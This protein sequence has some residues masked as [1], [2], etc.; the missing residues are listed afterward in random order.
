MFTGYAVQPLITLTVELFIKYQYLQTLQYLHMMTN[1]TANNTP[2]KKKLRGLGRG[3]D[4]LL[5]I[6]H[7]NVTAQT[8]QASTVLT[9]QLQSGAYQPRTHM[10]EA[11][12]NTLAE[13]IKSQGLIQPILVRALNT[14]NQGH[15]Q[16]EIIAGERRWRAS[17]IAGLTEVPVLI[18]DISNENAAVIALIENIQREN[19]NPLEEAQGINRLIDE[20]GLTHD[21]AAHAVGRSRSAVSNLLRLLNLCQPVQTMLIAGDLDMGH[22]RAL[23]PL[24]AANQIQVAHHIVQKQLSVRD[25]EKLVNTTLLKLEPA[26]TQTNKP[27]TALKTPQNPDTNRLIE[28]LSDSLGAPVSVD[29]GKNGK[30]KLT[31]SFKGLDA[32]QGII[33]KIESHNA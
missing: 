30:G 1:S 26:S 22:A 9:S 29:I 10:D 5:G 2:A 17:Q 14:S 13:S 12:L 27:S 33:E 18:K 11:A 24:D 7:S 20:F 28:R 16:Y 4:V 31:I 15:A 6:D 23:L 25:A 19:L 21:V 3:L 32:L 8:G